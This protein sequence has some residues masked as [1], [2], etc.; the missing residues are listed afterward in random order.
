MTLLVPEAARSNDYSGSKQ[1]AASTCSP[2]SRSSMSTSLSTSQPAC[3]RQRHTRNASGNDGYEE[4]VEVLPSSDTRVPSEQHSQI[5]S[6]IS[7]APFCHSEAIARRRHR[8]P[9]G[10]SSLSCCILA[11]SAFPTRRCKKMLVQW[12]D[13]AGAIYPIRKPSTWT[14]D[15]TMPH[16]RIN[17]SCHQHEVLISATSRI[18][19]TAVIAL[20]ERPLSS[21]LSD[22]ASEARHRL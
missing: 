1:R 19:D 18:L 13:R 6:R 10:R 5:A 2:P 12:S 9:V 7:P 4:E 8:Y 3:T 21:R 17:D 14:V 22:L 20:A 15:E 11:S 16:H